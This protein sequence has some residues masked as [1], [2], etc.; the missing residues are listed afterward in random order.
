VQRAVDSP[1][2]LR[3]GDLLPRLRTAIPGPATRAL[4]RRAGRVESA[5]LAPP[6]DSVDAFL[7]AEACGSNVLDV[8]GNRYLDFTSG[9]GVA[10]IGHRHPRVVAA[11]RAQAG[12]LIHGLGDAQGH[13]LRIELAAR[14]ARQVPI[15]EARVAFAVS[16]AD[17]VE[18]AVKTALL[19]TGRRRV[20]GFT[21]AYHG[22]SLG[23][24]AL[25]S[26]PRFRAVA[27]GHLHRQVNHLPFGAP[28]ATLATALA[29]VPVA[30][31]VVEPI[32]GREG[33]VLPPAG[34][35]LTVA[36]LCRRNGAL[37]VVDEILT[38]CGRTGRWFAVEHDDVE[39]DLLCCG[40]ALGGGLPI[41][42]L[43]GRA[44]LLAAW[45]EP[46]EARHTATFVAQPLACAA[47]LATLEVLAEERLV[48]RGA[49]L[50][51][52][53]GAALADWPERFPAVREVRGRGALW[54]I[55]WRTPAAAAA[56]VL[57]ARRRGLLVLAGGATGCV[58]QLLPPLTLTERQLDCALAVL[59]AAA[60]E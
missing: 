56:F 49:Q 41:A 28:A 53:L 22:V 30:A 59:R 19:A 29:A 36:E 50:G 55:E 11:V 46:G 52:R 38:G 20:V 26:R 58:A 40:K 14:L 45:D 3:R 33:V 18:L 21:P 35:L 27:R 5:G 6:M 23:A 31:V 9:F 1:P 25:S 32:V 37:L 51:R 48:A 7:W 43:V 4:A 8:D 39:P 24:L 44:S 12:R 54:G 10:A 57:R 16:G 34:W 60:A 47:A 42:A 17:A 15:R 2:R 13:P